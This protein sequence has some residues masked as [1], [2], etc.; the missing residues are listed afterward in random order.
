MALIMK[1]VVSVSLKTVE[2]ANALPP[3]ETSLVSPR[4]TPAPLFQGREISWRRCQGGVGRFLP[5]FGFPLAR[6]WR[7][8]QRVAAQKMNFIACR[9]CQRKRTSAA[10]R[11]SS[12]QVFKLTSYADSDLQGGS[13]SAFHDGAFATLLIMR[14]RAIIFSAGRLKRRRDAQDAFHWRHLCE[15]RAARR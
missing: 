13:L 12:K 11:S 10:L 5:D 4:Q 1:R 3:L 6:E 9:D 8:G 15:T 2:I 7:S 14:G